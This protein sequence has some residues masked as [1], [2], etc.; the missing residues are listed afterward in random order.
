MPSKKKNQFAFIS[1]SIITLVSMLVSNKAQAHV[2]WFAR[3]DLSKPP[4]QVA[5]VFTS[6][7]ISLLLLSVALL[8]IF[9]CIDRYCYRRQIFDAIIQRITVNENTA[10]SIMRVA[11]FVFFAALCVYR[12]CGIGFVLTPELHC[13]NPFITLIQFFAAIFTLHKKTL[14]LTGVAILTLYAIGLADYGLFHML[15]YLIFVGIGA[16]FLLSSLEN[17]RWSTHRYSILILCTGATLLWASIEKWGYPQWTYPLLR[18]E[19][20]LLMGMTPHFYMILAGFVEFNI[21]FL[22]ISSFSFFARI[23]AIG[24]NAVFILAIYKFGLVDAVGHLLIITILTVFLLRGP[25]H[26][27]YVVAMPHRNLA[28]EACWMTSLYLVSFGGVFILYYIGYLL[29]A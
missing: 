25:A 7:F 15:D 14:P 28:I 4:E 11:T 13:S 24:L 27:S 1:I 26:G 21:T 12:A 19:P 9:Y 6:E 20:E 23:I 18:R 3:Y 16:Y 17:G 29:F 2:K 5:L 22:L 10:L 8:F